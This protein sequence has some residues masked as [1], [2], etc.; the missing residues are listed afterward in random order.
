MYCS[1]YQAKVK[2]DTTWF[3]TGTLRN[4]DHWVFDR[5]LDVENDLMEFFVARDFEEKFLDLAGYLLEEGYISN[6]EKLENRAK[7]EGRI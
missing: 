4:E 1:Y 5:T 7:I 2:K 6:L 3:V